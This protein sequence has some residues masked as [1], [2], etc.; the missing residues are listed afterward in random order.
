[1]F[2]SRCRNRNNGRIHY[3]INNYRDIWHTSSN[4]NEATQW[5]TKEEAESFSSI[6]DEVIEL[7][8]AIIEY[9]MI[10]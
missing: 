5:A 3:W 7:N 2:V 10:I 9:L 8:Q 4:P 6:N 1:M